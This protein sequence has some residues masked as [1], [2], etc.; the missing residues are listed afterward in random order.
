M[1]SSICWRNTLIWIKSSAKMRS[2]YIKSFWCAWIELLNSWKLQR[3]YHYYF[4]DNITQWLKGRVNVLN[5]A[6]RRGRR[7]EGV[8]EVFDQKACLPIFCIF[9]MILLF[10]ERWHRKRRYSGFDKGSQLSAGSVRRTFGIGGRTK[11]IYGQHT[12]AIIQV[13]VTF[14]FFASQFIGNKSFWIQFK[15]A[16]NAHRS[17]FNV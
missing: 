7:E 3:Y 12:N 16:R 13:S 17:H 1:V 6:V 8:R 5:S 15:A 2:I 14:K 10:T 4:L 9:L 11:R